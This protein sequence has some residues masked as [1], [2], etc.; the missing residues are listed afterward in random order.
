MS[1]I[2]TID[3]SAI[4]QPELH[5][6]LLS[7]VAPRPICFASTIDAAGNVNLSPFSFFNVFSSNPPM[8]IFSPSRSGRDNSLKHSHQNIKEVAEVVINI[9]DYPIV[10]Q[11]SLSSTAYEKGVNEFIKSGLT[12]VPSK[13]VRPPRVAEAPISFEC[14]VEQVIELA[15]TPGAGNLI[16][17]KVELIHINE[18]FMDEQG[19]LDPLK[20]DLVGRMGGS[21]Y[22]RASGNSLFEI[23][24][25]IRNKGI[26]VDQLPK[27]IQN[28]TVLTGNNLGRLGNLE[29]IPTQ[30]EI[31]HIG[32]DDEIQMLSKKL[33]GN[34]EKLKKELHWVSQQ[35]LKDNDIEKA[36][37][38]LMYAEKLG[39]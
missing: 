24:K 32:L 2:K 14:K 3:P 28:S 25:P 9:V 6:Y 1:N 17:A 29:K 20:L 33:D 18:K 22:T 7:A 35:M 39:E 38:V 10:E 19:K 15:D 4:P 36:L 34:P 11:M 37:A 12:Q 31:E 30:E 8:M 26:G 16:L 27:S 5:S 13:K 21:W 23:P